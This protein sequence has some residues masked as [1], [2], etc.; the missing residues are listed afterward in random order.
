MT[1]MIKTDIIP[2]KTVLA[3]EEGERIKHLQEKRLAIDTAISFLRNHCDD[4]YVWDAFV[5][6][7][8]ADAVLDKQGVPI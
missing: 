4:P 1:Q 3:R 5:S 7:I 6:L 8:C 2:L